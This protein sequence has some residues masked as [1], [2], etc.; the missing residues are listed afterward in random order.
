M[1][2]LFSAESAALYYSRKALQ[3]NVFEN[4]GNAAQA[5]YHNWTVVVFCARLRG[6]IM[7]AQTAI[8]S[9]SGRLPDG[10]KA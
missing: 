5:S 1:L 4:M 9:R 6:I 10:G 8:F 3:L 2:L 7:R